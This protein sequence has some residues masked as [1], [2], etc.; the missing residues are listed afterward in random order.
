MHAA[1]LSAAEGASA[2]ATTT[3]RATRAE[4]METEAIAAAEKAE[5]CRVYDNMAASAELAQ[6]GSE[7]EG[8]EEAI[9]QVLREHREHRAKMLVRHTSIAS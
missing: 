6:R 2:A 5:A 1:S 8:R 9:S 3:A 7:L 4:A